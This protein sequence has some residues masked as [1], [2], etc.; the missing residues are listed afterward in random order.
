M[1]LPLETAVKAWFLIV[2]TWHNTLQIAQNSVHIRIEAKIDSNIKSENLGSGSPSFRLSI[3]VR[4]AN[5]SFLG[6]DAF[7]E[8]LC[9]IRYTWNTLNL[10]ILSQKLDARRGNAIHSKSHSP[11]SKTYNST[12]MLRLVSNVCALTCP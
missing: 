12:P 10:E 3:C 6:R 4:T 2:Q 8:L 7:N 5:I 9:T 11:N 1:N